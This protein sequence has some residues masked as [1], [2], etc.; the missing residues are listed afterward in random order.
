M[1]I[2]IIIIMFG[3]NE[4]FIV[5]WEECHHV[6]KTLIDKAPLGP[7]ITPPNKATYFDTNN[8]VLALALIKFLYKFFFGLRG[9][10]N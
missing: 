5:R 2:I 3:K 1:S 7:I 8:L 9:F 4:E 6:L 10:F